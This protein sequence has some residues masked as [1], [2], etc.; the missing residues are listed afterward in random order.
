[1]ISPASAQNLTRVALF[2]GS[3]S[4]TTYLADADKHQSVLQRELIA[5]YPGQAIEVFNFAD[6]GEFIGR[7]LTTG[8]YEKHRESMQGKGLDL[9]ILRF[10]INDSKRFKTD[11]FAEQLKTFIKTLSADFPGVA[12]II[13][14]GFYIDYPAHYSSDRNKA[15]N[16]YWAVSK[17]VAE[18]LQLPFSDL[19]AFSEKETKAGNW[20]LRIRSQSTTAYPKKK[21]RFLFDASLDAEYGHDPKWF[22][23]VHPNPNG[24]RVAVKAEVGLIRTLFPEKLPSGH[25]IADTPPRSN[26]EFIALLNCPPERLVLRSKK[27]PDQLQSPTRPPAVI[28]PAAD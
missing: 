20:D 17:A 11:E 16:P 8:T 22:T 3:S 25:R 26:D 18:Q 12:V 1:M 7:Y 4:A 24:V 2:G 21:E 10:G 5:A 15:L 28:P 19:Y 14:N 9:A 23:D 13:E 27:N 6:N